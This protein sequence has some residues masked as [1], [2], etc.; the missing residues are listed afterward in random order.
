MYHH[1]HKSR[2][3]PRMCSFTTLQIQKTRVASYPLQLRAA[4]A[5]T[6]KLCTCRR[7]L[8]LDIVQ[9]TSSNVWRFKFVTACSPHIGNCSF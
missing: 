5:V 1:R 3:A 4:L 6:D 2:T 7:S 8:L 9:L